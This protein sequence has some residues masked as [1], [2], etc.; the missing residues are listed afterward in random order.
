MDLLLW[1]RKY[2]KKLSS[3]LH[4]FVVAI[5]HQNSIHKLLLLICFCLLCQNII[6]QV[7]LFYLLNLLWGHDYL[8]YSKQVIALF[9][10]KT[11]SSLFRLRLKQINLFLVRNGWIG[12]RRFFRC[13]FSFNKLLLSLWTLFSLKCRFLDLLN[14]L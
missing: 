10:L 2:L 3:I 5:I 9:L 11:R 7:H 6:Q 13:N 8:L 4:L 1:C 12:L 14:L